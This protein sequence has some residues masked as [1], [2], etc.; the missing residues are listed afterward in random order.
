MGMKAA[1]GKGRRNRSDSRDYFCFFTDKILQSEGKSARMSCLQRSPSSR[2]LGH[3]AFNAVTRVRIPLGTPPLFIAIYF[4]KSIAAI[5]KVAEKHDLPAPGILF[6]QKPFH[7]IVAIS[8]FVRKGSAV[9]FPCLS[10]FH[11]SLFAI[12]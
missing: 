10:Q 1:P 9:F 7:S 6:I 4:L 2:G 8:Y 3:R 11:S 12:S 5:L